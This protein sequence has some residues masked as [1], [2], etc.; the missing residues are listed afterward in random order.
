MDSSAPFRQHER[1][2]EHHYWAD[3]FERRRQEALVQRE[4]RRRQEIEQLRSY[5][6]ALSNVE[7]EYWKIVVDPVTTPEPWHQSWGRNLD[8][9]RCS[10]TVAPG[11]GRLECY[12]CPSVQHTWGC[13]FSHSDRTKPRPA[14][15]I[16]DGCGD[17]L[18]DAVRRQEAALTQRATLLHRDL[19]VVLLQRTIRM[20]VAR[21]AYRC[22]V[23]GVVKVQAHFRG[24]WARRDFF[25]MSEAQWRPLSVRAGLVDLDCS[26]GA[27]GASGREAEGGLSVLVTINH[28][29]KRL[30][31]TT[32]TPALGGNTLRVP[33]VSAHSTVVFTLVSQSL[34]PSRSTA[35][36]FNEQLRAV[37]SGDAVLGV[38]FEGQASVNLY[39][40]MVRS[41]PIQIELELGV[42]RVQPVDTNGSGTFASLSASSTGSGL[43]RE[44]KIFNLRRSTVPARRLNVEL[45]PASRWVTHCGWLGELLTSS[46]T[47][48]A[49]KWFVVLDGKTLRIQ[50]RPGDAKPRYIRHLTFASIKF[51]GARVLEI[52]AGGEWA[53]TFTC[54]DPRDLRKWHARFSKAICGAFIG[55]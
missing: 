42:C 9:E 2:R 49:K 54:D 52:R 45:W 44:A 50:A 16:C 41:R 30:E 3:L 36:A 46:D 33:C 27:S 4:D 22:L 19:A 5:R 40:C 7:E 18:E 29:G 37:G 31:F 14:V 24:G 55:A 6:P 13:T 21:R 32:Q 43:Q 26:S 28:R 51:R 34:R 53:H 10:E 35:R 11:A 1:R 23:S 17:A 15:W 20:Q 12:L 25:S 8:C 39:D 47:E 48:P 38:E